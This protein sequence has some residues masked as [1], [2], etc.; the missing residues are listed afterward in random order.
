MKLE[1]RLYI[2]D[3]IY[4]V[5]NQSKPFT[6]KG[7][8]SDVTKFIINVGVDNLQY[9]FTNIAIGEIWAQ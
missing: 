6:T 5:E 8:N 7:L 4:L 1:L 2:K 3:V 9:R